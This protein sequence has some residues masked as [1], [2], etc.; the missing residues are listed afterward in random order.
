MPT[1]PRWGADVGLDFSAAD[2]EAWD[3]G[4]ARARAGG[5]VYALLYFVVSGVVPAR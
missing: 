2:L 5:L 4:I 1:W 3:H